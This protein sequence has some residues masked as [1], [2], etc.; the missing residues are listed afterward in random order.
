MQKTVLPQLHEIL[1]RKFFN[2]VKQPQ[3]WSELFFNKMYIFLQGWGGWGNAWQ[4]QLSSFAKF[5]WGNMLYRNKIKV[6]W[7]WDYKNFWNIILKRIRVETKSGNYDP[8]PPTHTCKWHVSKHGKHV[9]SH[10]GLS[11]A[12]HF[13]FFIW[14]CYDTFDLDIN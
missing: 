10:A 2:G 5:C 1:H 8:P 7:I 12:A 4:L 11:Y 9:K 6:R 14:N 13:P 3:V